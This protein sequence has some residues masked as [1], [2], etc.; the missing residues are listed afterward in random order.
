M[1]IKTNS[2]T[3]TTYFKIFIFCR[4][5]TDSMGSPN[6]SF[7]SITKNMCAVRWTLLTQTFV[8]S[9]QIS[10]SLNET[11][12]DTTMDGRSISMVVKA[13]RPNQWEEVQTSQENGK[14][15]TLIRTFM[16]D[17]M[18]IEMFVGN[19]NSSSTFLRRT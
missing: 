13:T 5:Q 15:T 6:S 12:V 10:F 2:Y 14:T 16:R 4:N 19:V 11:V 8:K 3:Y 7:S 1:L 17:K 18:F 9:H